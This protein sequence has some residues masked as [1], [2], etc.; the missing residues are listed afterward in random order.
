LKRRA[1]APALTRL[2]AGQA[3]VFVAAKLDW[4]SRSVADFARLLGRAN[5]KGWRLPLLDLGA[6]EPVPVVE[7]RAVA[8]RRFPPT[9]PVTHSTSPELHR[10]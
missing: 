8:R 2:D 7:A 3:D 6:D 10:I 5:A 4:V 9:A 1:L